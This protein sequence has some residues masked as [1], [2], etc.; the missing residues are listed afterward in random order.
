[1]LK[2][3]T[4]LATQCFEQRLLKPHNLKYL[5]AWKARY[6]WPGLGEDPSIRITTGAHKRGWI[7]RTELRTIQS[8]TVMTIIEFPGVCRFYSF[9]VILCTKVS[10]SL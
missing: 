9:M 1:L 8:I 6:P 10:R 2:K 7:W 3:R 4:P 5:K